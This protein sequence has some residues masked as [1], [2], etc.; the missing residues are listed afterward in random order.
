MI[1]FE[2]QNGSVNLFGL[3]TNTEPDK[4]AKSFGIGVLLAMGILIGGVAW[5]SLADRRR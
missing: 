3:G 5:F 4:T 2:T 1:S